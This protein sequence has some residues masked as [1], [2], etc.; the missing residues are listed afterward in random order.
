LQDVHNGIGKKGNQKKNRAKGKK[1]T[2]LSSK[3]KFGPPNCVMNTEGGAC[4][5]TIISSSNTRKISGK[6]GIL[7]KYDFTVSELKVG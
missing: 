7:C 1:L 6:F 5:P 2:V 4:L 3:N